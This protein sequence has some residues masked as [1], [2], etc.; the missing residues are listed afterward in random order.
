MAVSV[1]DDMRL[2]IFDPQTSGGL[3]VAVEPSATA[4]V[5]GRLH[6]AGVPARVVGR[7]DASDPGGALVRVE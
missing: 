2:V 5:M 3:L 6:E 7:I 4:H 1:T